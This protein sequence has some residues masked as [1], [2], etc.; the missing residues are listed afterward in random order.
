[1]VQSLPNQLRIGIIGGG[2]LG[3][4]LMEEG[5]R[6]DLHFNTLDNEDAPARHL[7]RNH[8]HGSLQ[9]E[10]AIRTLA[11]E[12]DILTYEIEHISLNALQK[13]ESEGKEIIP[14]ASVLQI[15]QDKGLQKLFYQKNN[16][17]SPDF[18]L[19]KKADDWASALHEL[20]NPQTFVAKTCKGGYDGK[21]VRICKAGDSPMAGSFVL[22]HFVE[23]EK[24][25]SVIVGVDRLGKAK[26]FPV[27]E[28]V[29]DPKLNLVDTLLCPARIPE[30]ILKE[31]EQIAI[32]VAKALGSPGLFAI[33]LF[34]DKNGKLW[35]NET[36]PRPHNSGHHTIESC[37]TSQYEQLIRILCGWPLGDT[38]SI[39]PATMINIIGPEGLTGKY[40]L[41][42]LG[43]LLGMP[44]IY[45]HL[46][47]KT[48]TRPGRKLGH[49][50]VMAETVEEVLKKT[51]EVK[52][53]LAIQA[54]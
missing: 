4:M 46:Y 48:E 25:L 23:C 42:N 9:D 33:E 8:I 1:M 24:E 52:V 11:L 3:C 18:R 38:T 34:L 45:I 36:A 27:V 41:T 7:A 39:S 6:Y 44:G 31:A 5:F 29:F 28:M 20:S 12:S 2:Q 53:L 13:L 43:I 26:C 54:A 50:T 37:V 30:S 15:I 40:Q 35:V 17:T 51:N 49:I 16:I 19:V 14:S 21:G 22:E 32:S 47:G 10:L